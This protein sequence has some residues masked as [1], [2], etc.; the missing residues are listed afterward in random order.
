MSGPQKA[1]LTAEVTPEREKADGKE[2]V[3][4]R[5]IQNAC[6]RQ[7]KMNAGPTLWLRSPILRADNQNASHGS[8]WRIRYFAKIVLKVWSP[9]NQGCIV[10]ATTSRS[11]KTQTFSWTFA[12]VKSIDALNTTL[13]LSIMRKTTS[14]LLFV[15]CRRTPERTSQ[16]VT[17]STRWDY[18]LLG[19]SKL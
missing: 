6:Y 4:L 19:A 9:K 3:Q 13:W 16:L 10:L 11:S 8:D 12:M 18:Q 2:E 14:R 15:W 7:S 17:P 1:Q 5:Q